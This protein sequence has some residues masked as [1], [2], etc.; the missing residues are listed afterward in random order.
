MSYLSKYE[1]GLGL[2]ELEQLFWTFCDDYI[3]IA[4]NRLYKPE[5]Y[6][7]EA[8]ESAQ[9]ASSMVLEGIL[10]LFSIYM[11]HITEEIYQS[12][13]ADIEGAKS[14]HISKYLDLGEPKDEQILKQGDVVCDIVSQ[15]RGYKSSNGLSLK[16]ELSK[17]TLTGYDDFVKNCAED[18]KAVCNI[19]TLEFAEGEKGVSIE[20]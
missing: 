3:E 1:M 17:V 6:G 14:I 11:P 12:Y 19:K 9:Y 18:I 5:I 2:N 13:Y 4:K 16:E 20:A 8:K 7:E 15:I 10:K